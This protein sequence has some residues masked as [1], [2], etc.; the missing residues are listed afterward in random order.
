MAEQ[1]KEKT[2]RIK[3]VRSPIGY[4]ENQKRTVKALG[5]HR[6]NQV[7]EKPDNEAVRGMIGTIAHLV[8]IVE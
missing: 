8:E 6:L 3:L 4:P 5:L 1:T 2:I 7:V